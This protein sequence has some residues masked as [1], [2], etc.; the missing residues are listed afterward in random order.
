MIVEES[1]AEKPT[2]ERATS[3]KEG[4][5]VVLPPNVDL[6]KAKIVLYEFSFSPPCAKVRALLNFYSIPF[7]SNTTTPGQS[8]EG[9]DNA[10]KK[11]PRMTIDGFQINDSAVIFRTLAPLL[12]GSPL[13]AAEVELEKSNNVRGF[14]GALEKETASS[15]WGIAGAV[16]ALYGTP[17]SSLS[18]YLVKPV[19]KYAAGLVW[20]L[21]WTLMHFAPH[22]SDGDSL[23]F[24]HRY[25]GHLL[26][27]GGPYFHGEKIG[28]VDLSIY[29]TL[30]TFLVMHAPMADHVLDAAEL[31]SWFEKVDAAVEAVKPIF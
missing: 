26:A 18:A 21:P 22:G 31:R 5:D 9:I 25:Y 13:T 29:G 28:P 1:T 3:N 23:K 30:K 19:A 17:S 11:V 24:A 20:P 2:L 8:K 10:Y 16:D 4:E 27:T 12:S 15:F 7:E 14:M 6:K